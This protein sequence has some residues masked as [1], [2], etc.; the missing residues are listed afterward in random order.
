LYNWDFLDSSGGNNLPAH[1]GDTRDPDSITR[2]RSPG[3]GNGNL[4]QFLAWR[5]PCTEESGGLQ[6]TA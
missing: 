4:P 3:E 5:I 6:S 2:L 1:V